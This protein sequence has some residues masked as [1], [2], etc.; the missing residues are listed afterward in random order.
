[1]FKKFKQKI[2]YFVKNEFILFFQN[3]K[4]KLKKFHYQIQNKKNKQKTKK[5]T[6]KQY[7]KIK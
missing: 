2:F 4:Q 1:M 3:N 5:N 6:I 7:N